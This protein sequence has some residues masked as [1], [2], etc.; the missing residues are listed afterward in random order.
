VTVFRK[1][2]LESHI[3]RQQLAYLEELLS[4]KPFGRRSAISG[5]FIWRYFPSFSVERVTL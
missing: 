5:D 1:T 4:F 2:N 3:L